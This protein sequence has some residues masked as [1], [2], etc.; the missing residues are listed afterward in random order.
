MGNIPKRQHVVQKRLLSN[1]TSTYK[2]PYN[3]QRIWQFDKRTQKSREISLKIAGVRRNFLTPKADKV[4]THLERECSPTLDLVIESE[5]MFHKETSD[6]QK[7]QEWDQT[8]FSLYRYISAQM[9]RTGLFREKVSRLLSLSRERLK[10]FHSYIFQPG[11]PKFIDLG[12]RSKNEAKGKIAKVFSAVIPHKSSLP[13]LLADGLAISLADVTLPLIIINKS[14]TPYIQNDIGLVPFDPFTNTSMKLFADN[15]TIVSYLAFP[16]S[17]Q[18]CI[19]LCTTETLLQWTKQFPTGSK[20]GMMLDTDEQSRDLTN[21]QLV[22]FAK[23]FIYSSRPL[24]EIVKTRLA[25]LQ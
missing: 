23:R 2:A 9:Q 21:S 5:C 12:G 14:S 7:G 16:V 6:T 8:W 19:H 1:F 24:E 22:R 15:E 20:R 4:I 18:I 3:K 25:T 11:E 10:E 13:P 17:P